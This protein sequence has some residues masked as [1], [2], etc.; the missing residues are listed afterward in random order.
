MKHAIEEQRKAKLKE[1]VDHHLTDEH[2][3]G[4]LHQARIAA[5][6]G[7]REIM[8]LQFPHEL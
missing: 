1:L 4:I 2:W 3:R 5:E 6:H 7:E 8:V